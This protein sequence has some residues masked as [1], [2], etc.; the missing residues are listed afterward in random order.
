LNEATL[1]AHG[2]YSATSSYWTAVTALGAAIIDVLDDVFS[3]TGDIKPVI[4]SQTRR[5]R[6]ESY[7][8]DLT[9]AAP[10]RQPRWLRTRQEF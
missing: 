10:S 7:T 3:S 1:E 6:G 2:I 9:E 4:Y 5:D 8:F